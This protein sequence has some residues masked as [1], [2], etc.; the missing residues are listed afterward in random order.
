MNPSTGTNPLHIFC[1]CAQWCVICREFEPQFQRLAADH[2]E[3]RWQSLDIEDHEALLANIDIENFPTVVILNQ[4]KQV[5]FAGTIEPRIDSLQRL[6]QSAQAE[7][8]HLSAQS[9]QA[10]QALTVL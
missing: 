5:C 7:D 6:I 3:H 8:L 2:P 9:A 1:L 10:W 4:A